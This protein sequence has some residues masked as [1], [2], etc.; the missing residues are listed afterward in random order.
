M[1]TRVSVRSLPPTPCDL[2]MCRVHDNLH[3]EYKVLP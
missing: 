1:S 2:C 3:L